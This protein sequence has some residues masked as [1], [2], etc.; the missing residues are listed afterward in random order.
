MNIYLCLFAE[1]RHYFFSVLRW[2]ES[3]EREKGN[4]N[5]NVKERVVESQFMFV[6][7]HA[8]MCNRQWMCDNSRCSVFRT[9]PVIVFSFVHLFLSCGILKTSLPA[10][11]SDRY[12]FKGHHG[13][14]SFLECS[15]VFCL[16]FSNLI[17]INCNNF[18]V[19]TVGLFCVN[20]G[21]FMGRQ[22]NWSKRSQQ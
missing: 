12:A 18:F 14:F 4:K 2:R 6:Y 5:L 1:K 21:H 17:C 20:H 7:S 13:L 10:A 9:L 22:D 15:A 8:H 11:I 3:R 16:V 19:S